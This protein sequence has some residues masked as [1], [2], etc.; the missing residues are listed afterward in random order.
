MD[1]P[2]AIASNDYLRRARRIRAIHRKNP[3]KK[4][5]ALKILVE[6]VETMEHQT[7]ILNKKSTIVKKSTIASAHVS[8]QD[9]NIL[10]PRVQRRN[11]PDS[12]ILGHRPGNAGDFADLVAARSMG[13]LLTQSNRLWLLKEAETRGIG[14]FEANL[15]IAAVLH[16]TGKIKSPMLG[17]Q[18]RFPSRFKFPTSFATVVGLQILILTA[19]W[20]V[21]I[22]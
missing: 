11:W 4:Q 16:Q 5:Q 9:P 6:T 8:W 13:S 18:T 19:V 3:A 10:H 7:P 17:A 14:R 22:H 1:C 20:I 21:F 12:S 2:A 15:I